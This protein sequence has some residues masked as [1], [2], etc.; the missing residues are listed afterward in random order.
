MQDCRAPSASFSSSP[1][2]PRR[3]P[4]RLFIRYGRL[5]RYVPGGSTGTGRPQVVTPSETRRAPGDTSTPESSETKRYTPHHPRV[6]T[7]T[8]IP[9]W[10]MTELLSNLTTRR[11][12]R[13]TGPTSTLRTSP[14][15]EPGVYWVTPRHMYGTRIRCRGP[16]GKDS[17]LGLEPVPPLT[18]P[19]PRGPS[20]GRYP[21]TDCPST[22]LSTTAASDPKDSRHKRRTDR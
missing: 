19:H 17:L 15:S 5:P 14:G 6:V 13:T 20:G 3:S 2:L 16:S 9:S 1:R 7:T 12:R 8:P 22:C 18:L 4:S 11:G 10:F 21:S